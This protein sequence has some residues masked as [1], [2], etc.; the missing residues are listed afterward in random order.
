M[1]PEPE[2]PRSRIAAAIA[3]AAGDQHAEGGGDDIEAF[4][5]ILAD[6]VERSAAAGAGLI[7]DVDDLLD[8]FEMRWQRTTVVLAW[9][10]APGLGHRGITC[11]LRA[12]ERG[13]DILQRQLELIGIK[14]LGLAAEPVPLEGL[15]DRLQPLDPSIGLALG[16]AEIG[17]CAG[18]FEDER[19]QRVNVIG[20]VR[21]HQHM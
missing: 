11:S 13:L 5:N 14:L 17:Q 20:K 8:P 9:A 4:G 2:Q 18:L 19:T 1:G 10:F 6:L 16:I 21:F 7:L 15:D 12:T 3:R